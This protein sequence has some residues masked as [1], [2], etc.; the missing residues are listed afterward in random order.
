MYTNTLF[1]RKASNSKLLWLLNSIGVNNIN[2][3]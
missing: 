3:E 2:I 1:F